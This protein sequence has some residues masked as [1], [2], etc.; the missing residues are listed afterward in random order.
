MRRV[1][2]NPLLLSLC[3]LPALARAVDIQPGLW[4]ISSSN[5]Q[6]DGQAVPGME[7]SWV[8]SRW[9]A[10]AGWFMSETGSW[11]S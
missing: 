2:S 6:V 9:K 1:F 4:E 7:A 3:L 5:M 11:L 10:R 8:V